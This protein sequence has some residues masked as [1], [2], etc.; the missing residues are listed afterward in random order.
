MYR[1][2]TKSELVLY[3]ELLGKEYISGC[4]INGV[5]HLMEMGHIESHDAELDVGVM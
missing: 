1:E 3:E 5:V 2:L 4:I